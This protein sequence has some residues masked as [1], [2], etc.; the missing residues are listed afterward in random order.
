MAAKKLIGR[1]PADAGGAGRQNIWQALKAFPAEIT[2]PKLV[3]ATGLH[4]SSVTR[5]LHALTAA[6]YLEARDAGAG[7]ACTWVLIKDVGFHAPRVRAD[8]SKVTQGAAYEQIWRGMYMLKTFSFID[9]VQHA[10]IEI[11]EAT[12]KDYCKRLLAAGYL[13][14]ERKAAPHRGQIAKYR[15]IRNSGPMA[16]QVQRVQRIFDPNTGL[17]HDLEGGQ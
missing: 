10:S 1:L 6:G 2:V 7:H 8:G 3:E 5:Y 9:L 13:R 12:A 14:V 11:S 17:V 15:L 16:P 4:R